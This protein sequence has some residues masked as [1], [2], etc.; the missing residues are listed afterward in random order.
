MYLAVRVVIVISLLCVDAVSCVR[1]TAP[2]DGVRGAVP[3]T[4]YRAPYV[5]TL[6]FPPENKAQSTK[7][8][9]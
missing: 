2:R 8:Y 1:H 4:G 3:P 6:S 7:A 5:V 9:I